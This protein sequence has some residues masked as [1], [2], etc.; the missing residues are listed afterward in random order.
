MHESRFGRVIG[1]LVSPDKTFRSIAERPTWAVP[2]V[3][4]VLLSIGVA[5]VLQQRLDQG[6]M[7][8][9]QMEKME[10]M[11]VTIGEEQL[12]KMQSDAENQSTTAR[13][14]GLV[15]GALVAAGVYFL[16][17]A[18]FLGT[19]RLTGSELGFKQSLGATVHAMLPQGVAALLNIPLALSRPTISPEEML[20][21]GLLASSLRPLAPEGSAVLASLLGSLDF[22][23]VWSVVLLILGYRAV[24]KVSTQT[25]ATVVVVLWGIWVL[26]KAGVAAV[27]N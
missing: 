15:F 8:K 9:Y 17:A 26:G 27:F 1:V 16:L 2:L 21:G 5:L 6:E 19:F 18:L 24:A 11:G 7:L 23:T 20:S 14:V 4:L 25:S 13:T 12:E 10:K 22:F 3:L